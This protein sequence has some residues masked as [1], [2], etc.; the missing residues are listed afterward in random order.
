MATCLPISVPGSTVTRIAILSFPSRDQPPNSTRPG[1]N[2]T[3]NSSGRLEPSCLRKTFFAY[4]SGSCIHFGDFALEGSGGL[5]IAAVAMLWH[6][7][8]EGASKPTPFGWDL[9]IEA[10]GSVNDG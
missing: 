2:P 1:S 3:W 5:G 7:T 6:E 10:G 4:S 8:V 9:P